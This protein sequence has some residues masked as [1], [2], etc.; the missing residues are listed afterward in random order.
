MILLLLL[1]LLVLAIDSSSPV[2]V[3]LWAALSLL[4]LGALRR[5]K[6][7]QKKFFQLGQ[8]LLKQPQG[9]LNRPWS[10]HVDAGCF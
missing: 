4:R 5:A 3:A 10:R 1:L 9:A 8:P 6:R 7:L 2:A